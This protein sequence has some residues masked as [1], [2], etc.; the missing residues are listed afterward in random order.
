[1]IILQLISRNFP[2]TIYL[3]WEESQKLDLS[4]VLESRH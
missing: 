4:N 2:Y 3:F 1:M